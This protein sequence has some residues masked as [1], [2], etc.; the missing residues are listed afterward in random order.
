MV[1]LFLNS[2]FFFLVFYFDFRWTATEKYCHLYAWYFLLLLISIDIHYLFFT[3]NFLNHQKRKRNWK[4]NFRRNSSF[5]LTERK[6]SQR[7]SKMYGSTYTFS[8]DFCINIFWIRFTWFESNQ[9]STP[10]GMLHS[11]HFY[12]EYTYIFQFQN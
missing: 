4:K 1:F 7:M 9:F 3:K 11:A 8:V 2:I 6:Y 5:K 10:I 12:F